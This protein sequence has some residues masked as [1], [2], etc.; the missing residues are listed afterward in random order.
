MAIATL[1]ECFDNPRVFTGVVKIRKGLAARLILDSGTVEGVHCWF[2]DFAR[3]MAERTPKDDPS[4]PKILA[5]V[6]AVIE[7]TA[8]AARRRVR[9]SIFM[10]AGALVAGA[11]AMWMQ[12]SSA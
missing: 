10:W 8:P 11:T 4:R 1:S 6:R 2:Y 5:A 9:K 7:L 3:T 12:A